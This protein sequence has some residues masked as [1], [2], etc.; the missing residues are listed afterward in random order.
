[1]VPHAAL[2]CKHLLMASTSNKDR[3]STQHDNET[4]VFMARLCAAKPGHYW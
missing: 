4:Q 1:M 2:A 3:V